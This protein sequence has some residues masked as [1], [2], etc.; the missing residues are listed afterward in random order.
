M[1]PLFQQKSPG[2][3][4][5]YVGEGRPPAPWSV[6]MRTP[7]SITSTYAD[8]Y[9]TVRNRTA[10]RM[11]NTRSARDGPHFDS[12]ATGARFCAVRAESPLWLKKRRPL[13]NRAEG[14]GHGCLAR[15]PLRV[16][17]G[18]DAGQLRD[19]G[20]P[21]AIVLAIVFEE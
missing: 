16:S 4:A 6:R 19:L 2:F 20:N 8:E 9:E 15:S 1:Q 10:V 7:S 3:A 5:T 13:V 17:V 18:Q 11:W 21:V 14:K 12:W